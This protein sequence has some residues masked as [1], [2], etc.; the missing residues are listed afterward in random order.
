MKN[1]RKTRKEII[2]NKI[3]KHLYT[4]IQ[5][6]AIVL[7]GTALIINALIETGVIAAMLSYIPLILGIGF[8][9]AGLMLYR[10]LSKLNREID[11]YFRAVRVAERQQAEL[12]KQRRYTA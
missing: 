5:V 4:N 11:K 6:F 10:D 7:L 1:T 9:F 2:I 3:A 12:S 8:G